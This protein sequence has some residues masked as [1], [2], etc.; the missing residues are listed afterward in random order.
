[1]HIASL[2]AVETTIPTL[3]TF[4]VFGLAILSFAPNSRSIRTFV[5]NY[6]VF[7]LAG[8]VALVAVA[9]ILLFLFG[10]ET[11]AKQWLDQYGLF[12]LFFIFILEGAMMLYFAPSETV[13]PVGVTV[14][15]KSPSDY[16]TIAVIVVVAVIASTAGQYALFLLAKRGGREYLLEKPWFRIDDSSLDRFDHWLE[17]WGPLA[18][19][20][21]NTLPFT[22]GM[23][24]VPA[25]FGEMKDRNFIILSALGSLS[26]E[27]LL[28]IF[29]PRA[30]AILLDAISKF[31]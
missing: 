25:G 8:S 28:A 29:G 18:I 10:D 13:V 30:F 22:R 3:L 14:L 23:L 5:A 27:T 16:R 6:G 9:G 31:F 4:S 24:T 1:M 20:L 17:R 2:V 19:P 7:V 21:S 11:L 26:F 12:A 15:A